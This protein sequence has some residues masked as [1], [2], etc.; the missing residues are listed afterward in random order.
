MIFNLMLVFSSIPITF[1]VSQIFNPKEIFSFSKHQRK[2]T[3]KNLQFWELNK[4][5]ASLS[6]E[7][8][9]ALINV[10]VQ[11]Y[12]IFSETEFQSCLRFKWNC[13]VNLEQWNVN[14]TSI[15]TSYGHI[16][17]F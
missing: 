8:Q 7:K 1:N 14:S 17:N 15:K 5:F 6:I 10:H 13:I 4:Y 11:S 12:F 2:K 16:V 9:I 3:L